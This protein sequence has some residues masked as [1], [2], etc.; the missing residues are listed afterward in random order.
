MDTLQ[1]II[2]EMVEVISDKVRNQIKNNLFDLTERLDRHATI[3]GAVN[4][5]IAPMQ[6]QVTELKQ[7][8]DAMFEYNTTVF[9]KLESKIKGGQSDVPNFDEMIANRIEDSYHVQSKLRDFIEREI[10]NSETLVS[11]EEVREIIS[12]YIENDDEIVTTSSLTDVVREIIRD[13]ISFEVSV[14]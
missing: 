1:K 14:S 3:I 12:D 4:D 5:D 7:R 2:D 10:N 6:D 9:D 11:S 13:D 8:L